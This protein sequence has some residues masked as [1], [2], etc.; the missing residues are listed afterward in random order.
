[1]TKLKFKVLKWQKLKLKRSVLDFSL[2]KSILIKKKVATKEALP[3]LV[4]YFPIESYLHYMSILS[5]IFQLCQ[6]GP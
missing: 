3:I 2:F 1:M 4:T 5:I 6:F